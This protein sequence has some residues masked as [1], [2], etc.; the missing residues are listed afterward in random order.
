MKESF[1]KRYG[2]NKSALDKLEMCT[3]KVAIEK[4]DKVEDEVQ[5]TY[6]SIVG[7]VIRREAIKMKDQEVDVR[8]AVE[9]AAAGCAQFN[10]TQEALLKQQLKDDA[11]FMPKTI[12]R[13]LITQ[14]EK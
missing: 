12:K 10:K 5:I 13:K 1:F 2:V 3:V 9:L 7:E 11:S 8:R 14:K 6:G 4:I